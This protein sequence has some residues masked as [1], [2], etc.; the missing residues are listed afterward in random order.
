[1]S[2]KNVIL[3]AAATC[4][5]VGSAFASYFTD[6]VSIWVRDKSGNP[7]LVTASG[8]P[9]C[10]NNSQKCFIKVFTEGGG[11]LTIPQ[12]TIVTAGNTTVIGSGQVVPQTARTLGS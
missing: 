7:L 12:A 11:T 5:A 4:L 2:T 8:A 9:S 10:V 3:G 1:M 6:P